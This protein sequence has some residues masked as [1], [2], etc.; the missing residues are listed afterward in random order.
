M[1]P[2]VYKS[3]QNKD[4]LYIPFK[5]GPGGLFLLHWWSLM[6]TPLISSR[7]LQGSFVHLLPHLSRFI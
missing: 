1:V 4:N 3:Y 7:Y 2:V 6:K 5:N